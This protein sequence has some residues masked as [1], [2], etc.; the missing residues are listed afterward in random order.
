MSS[1]TM[2][3]FA[4]EA[5]R[6]VGK[7]QDKGIVIRVIGATVIGKHCPVFQHLHTS[8][9]RELTGIDFVTYSK[10][11]R[12]MK[13]LFQELGYKSDDRF[14][15]YFGMMCQQYHDHA[16]HRMAD[17]FFDLLEMCHTIGFRGRWN[18]TRQRLPWPTLC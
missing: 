12:S 7:A 6:I 3:E 8:M 9:K 15:A 2:S 4:D 5:T 17:I 11:N 13:S 16:N 18:L 14:N 1:V 10:F